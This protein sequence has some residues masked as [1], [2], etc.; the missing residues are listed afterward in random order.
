MDPLREL[1]PN[2]RIVRYFPLP[3]SPLR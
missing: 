1:A 3:Y 2:E